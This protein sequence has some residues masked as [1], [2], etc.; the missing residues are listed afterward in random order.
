M[1]EL[2]RRDVLALTL[3]GG[4]IAAA[5]AAH[6]ADKLPG[7]FAALVPQGYKLDPPRASKQGIMG[8]VSFIARKHFNGRHSVQDG[9]YRFELTM[10]Q[11]SAELVA[12]QGPGYKAQLESE[13]PRKIPKA[14]P[15]GLRIADPAVVMRYPWGTGI[16]QRITHKYVGAGNGPDEVEYTGLYIGCVAAGDT[17]KNFELRV[18][19]VGT[20]GEADGW[21]ASAAA[22]IAKAAMRDLGG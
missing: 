20:L 14:N 15:N 18:S 13:I 7:A 16:T 1:I 21:A 3:V 2:H 11:L 12:M 17:I 10:M 22:V 8:V 4:A 6:A 5:P 9:E 19:G